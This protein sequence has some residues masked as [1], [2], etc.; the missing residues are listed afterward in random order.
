MFL[1][2][3]L[4]AKDVGIVFKISELANLLAKFE[5][6]NILRWKSELLT[7]ACH[8]TDIVQKQSKK[9]VCPYYAMWM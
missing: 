1:V 9:E 2:R 5:L 8:H 6:L 4:F 3:S 7:Q